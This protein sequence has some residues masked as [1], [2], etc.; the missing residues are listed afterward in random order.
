VGR[1]FLGNALG[2]VELQDERCGVSLPEPAEFVYERRLY[3]APTLRRRRRDTVRRGC[4]HGGC[5]RPSTVHTSH[6]APAGHPRTRRSPSHP[7]VTLAPAG[8][9][10]T[11]RLSSHRRL[12]LCPAGTPAPPRAPCAPRATLALRATLAPRVSPR[13][14]RNR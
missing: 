2:E 14:H 11:C 3:H 1:R 5:S 8:H 4:R 7:Q 12:F 10:R 9:P 6:P 13:D